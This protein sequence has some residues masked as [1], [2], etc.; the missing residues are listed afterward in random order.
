M[1]ALAGSQSVSGAVCKVREGGGGVGQESQHTHQ[2]VCGSEKT[3][4]AKEGHGCPNLGSSSVLQFEYLSPLS[5]VS[6]SP[7]E[8]TPF[9]SVA[10]VPLAPVSLLTLLW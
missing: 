2:E 4:Q 3:R 7:H 6:G 9:F 8:V 5:G 1:G 10:H